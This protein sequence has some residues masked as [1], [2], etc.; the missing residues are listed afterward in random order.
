MDKIVFV[1]FDFDHFTSMICFVLVYIKLILFQKFV[2]DP[3]EVL[4]I[5]TKYIGRTM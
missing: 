1:V 2:L 3:D 4:D 5:R